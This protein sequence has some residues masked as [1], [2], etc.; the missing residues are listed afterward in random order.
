[1]NNTRP[2]WQHFR[3]LIFSWQF[4][5]FFLKARLKANFVTPPLYRRLMSMIFTL[6]LLTVVAISNSWIPF[7]FAWVFPL[8]ILYH[9]STL[10]QLCSE[11]YWGAIGSK[12]SKSHGRF[13]GETPPFGGTFQAWLTWLLR[14]LFYHLPVRVGVLSDPEICPH[15]FHHHYPKADKDWPNAIYNRQEQVDN[16]ANYREFWGIHNAMEA[17]FQSLAQTPSLSEAE[18]KSLTQQ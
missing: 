10:L 3:R 15:D 2:Y 4:H 17:V 6:L 5:W 11:H 12:E 8:T 1:M 16:G 14:M 18:I 9:I 13:C 7:L